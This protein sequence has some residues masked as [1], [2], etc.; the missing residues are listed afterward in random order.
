M[1]FV[2]F[3]RG[4]LISTITNIPSNLKEAAREL[5][6]KHVHKNLR[7]D[8]IVGDIIFRRQQTLL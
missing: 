7:N 5:N 3:Q 6:S 8:C 1:I 2:K 4:I